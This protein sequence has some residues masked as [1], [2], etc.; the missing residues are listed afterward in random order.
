MKVQKRPIT[1][2]AWHYEGDKM[3]PGLCTN[4]CPFEGSETALPH[5]H[6]LEGTHMVTVG[7]WIIRG[8]KGE[9]YPCKP[10]IF[11]AT[12]DILPEAK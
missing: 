6:T 2:D 12:Y 7:D 1:V 10:D 11:S 8:I 9:Y 3:L 4:T 5:I